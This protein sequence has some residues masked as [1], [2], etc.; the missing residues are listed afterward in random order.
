LFD[1]YYRTIF[2][3]LERRLGSSNLAED[4]A[5]ET[6]AVAFERRASFDARH[7][8]VAPWLF[9]IATNLLRNHRRSELRHLQVLGRL[10]AVTS[11][12]TS[13][14][15]VPDKAAA[16]EELRRVAEALS[17][18]DDKERDL[19]LLVASAEL[20]IEQAAQGLGIST[21]AAR[22]RLWRARRSLR[23][24]LA[25]HPSAFQASPASSGGVD[26]AKE[27]CL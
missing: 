15:A 14:D 3:Y 25:G 6:F 12:T 4:L 17:H 10:Q 1:R 19:V 26:L 13:H 23:S 21:G 11:L 7:R 9:G 22:L 24:E 2:R 8:D 5:A 20:T 18:L 27:N 16:R